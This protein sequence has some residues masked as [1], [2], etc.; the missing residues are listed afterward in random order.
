MNV[1]IT[2]RNRPRTLV[3]CGALLLLSL[4]TC[5]AAK[6]Q[7]AHPVL[8]AQFARID[9]G[10]S[11]VA[12]I[13]PSATGTNYLAQTVVNSPS[14]TVGALG[15]IRYIKSPF[16]GAEF[17]YHYARFTENFSYNA[18]GPGGPSAILLGVQTNATEYT[19]GYVAHTRSSYFGVQPF[20]AVG[21]GVIAFRPTARGG[22]GYQPQ[23]RAAYYYEVGAEQTI[24]NSKFGV[25][26]QFR[27]VIHLAPDYQTNYLRINK[28][29]FSSQP[30]IGFYY[31]F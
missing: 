9:V 21:A 30:T 10:V 2:G 24:F 20:A 7:D 1:G 5:T 22:L 19:F 16:V 26:A 13:T 11:A 17:N 14:T 27:Q 15:T 8:A 18:P 28:R 3:A 4:A 12:E 6:A 25:R 31:H 29:V 23:A